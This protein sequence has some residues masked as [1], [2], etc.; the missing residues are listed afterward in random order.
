M[1]KGQRMRL[2]EFVTDIGPP[3]TATVR[4]G[5]R[6]NDRSFF[7]NM[8]KKAGGSRVNRA[9]L[10]RHA[11]GGRVEMVFT[12]AGESRYPIKALFTLATPQMVENEEVSGEVLD[13][14]GEQLMRAAKKTVE[15]AI[16]RANGG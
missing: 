2:A 7:V 11:G 16:A 5:G 3:I 14:A 8:Y 13:F 12:R 9:H 10:R 1:F 6:L 15:K 4:D